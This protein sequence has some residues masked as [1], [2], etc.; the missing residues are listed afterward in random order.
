M[1]DLSINSGRRLSDQQVSSPT[2]SFPSSARRG[3]L[4]AAF[5]DLEEH[6]SLGSPPQAKTRTI[7][8]NEYEVMR[9]TILNSNIC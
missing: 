8:N 4:K 5:V 1:K 7:T 9:Y 6:L 2:A 3:I